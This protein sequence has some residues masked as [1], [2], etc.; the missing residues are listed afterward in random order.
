MRR[1]SGLLGTDRFVIDSPL[2]AREILARL[3]VERTSN[4]PFPGLGRFLVLEG[5]TYWY[6]SV[7]SRGKS[8]FSPVL[9]VRVEAAASGGSRLTCEL[10]PGRVRRGLGVCFAFAV[11]AGTVA[12]IVLAADW[13]FFAFLGLGIVSFLAVLRFV[14]ALPQPS[15][16]RDFLDHLT[17]PVT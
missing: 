7:L 5:S 6:V 10:G 3:T 15:R 1:G 8:A 13:A 16:L 14:F 12:C 4:I 17:A 2:S 11:I 9:R